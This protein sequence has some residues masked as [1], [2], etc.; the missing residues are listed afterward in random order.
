MQFRLSDKTRQTI[1][2]DTCT[3]KSLY[4]SVNFACGRT[5]CC[6]TNFD[7]CSK[8]GWGR[9][10]Y[11]SIYLSLS[12]SIYLSIYLSICLSVCRSVYLSIY[13]S[14]YIFGPQEPFRAHHASRASEQSSIKKG[15]HRAA[16]PHH[17]LNGYLAQRVPSLFL[18]SSFSMCLKCE[19]LKGMFPL[20]T[21]YP[22]S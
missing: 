14:I 15:A 2:H 19:A 22:L 5:Q 4:E 8:R 18:D 17:W 3:T 20:R 11:L 10:A 6:S 21:R 7:E 16:T 12:L 13:Q 1:T 9:P